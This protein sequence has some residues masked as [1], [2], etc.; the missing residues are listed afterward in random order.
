VRDP[1]PGG[2]RDAGFSLPELMV[3]MLITLVLMVVVFT[4]MR[5][6]Q[7]IFATE[8]GVTAMNENVRAA[9]DLLTREIQASGT[10]LRGMTAP[11]LGVAGE[12]GSGD[13]IAL[14]LGDPAAPVAHVRSAPLANGSTQVLVSTPAGVTRSGASL[15]YID[16]RGKQRP[17]YDSGDRYIVYNENH[18]TIGRITSAAVNGDGD[19]LI[20]Y[21]IDK[22][23]PRSAFGD[24]SYKP[25]SDASGALFARLDSIVFYRFDQEKQVIERRENHEPWAAVAGGI[26]GFPVRYRSLNDD[27][28]LTEPADEPPLDRE[29]IRSVVLTIRARTPDAEKDNP[30][31]RETAERFEITPRNMR[32]PKSSGEVEEPS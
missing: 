3:A 13:R 24:F 27:N 4:L 7:S 23:N 9:V 10:G 1:D 20:S 19:V 5:Q 14:L 29:A 26:L 8:T 28:T 21:E 16:D 6:N 30:R 31:Y 15:T 12:D 32:L 17:L 18:F 11:I 25:A 22:S 2:S